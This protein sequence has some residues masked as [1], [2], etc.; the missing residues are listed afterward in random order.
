MFAVFLFFLITFSDFRPGTTTLATNKQ[1]NIVKLNEMFNL[2]CYAE[3]N[4][5]AKYMFFDGEGKV[6]NNSASGTYTAVV[7]TRV[8]KVTY[9]CLP[10]N[11]FGNGSFK[12]VEV[13][14]HCKY[15]TTFAV[16][17]LMS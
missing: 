5:P 3:A 6:L 12:E 8:K 11:D 2:S 1:R 7:K 14:A 17:F 9:G 10:Y 16:L 15:P 13:T 4:P